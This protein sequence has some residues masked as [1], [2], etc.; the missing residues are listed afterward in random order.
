LGLPKLQQEKMLERPSQ[1]DCSLEAQCWKAKRWTVQCW[2]LH[3]SVTHC[4]QVAEAEVPRKAHWMAQGLDYWAV[5]LHWG[6]EEG[7]YLVE[8]VEETRL[9]RSKVV[10]GLGMAVEGER[11]VTKRVRRLCPQIQDGLRL[12]RL[13]VRF[14]LTG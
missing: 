3:Y 13:L 1:Q 5:E 7:Y 14:S 12:H 4:S 9:A 2:G 6:K 11:E 8:E 10:E